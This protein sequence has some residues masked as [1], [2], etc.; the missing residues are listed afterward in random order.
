MT[1]A[2]RFRIAGVDMQLQLMCKLLEASADSGDQVRTML[3][4]AHSVSMIHTCASPDSSSADPKLLQLMV[5]RPETLAPL[6]TPAAV[7]P[8]RT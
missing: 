1:H 6:R 3:A 8:N 7:I 2:Y 5:L 4:A